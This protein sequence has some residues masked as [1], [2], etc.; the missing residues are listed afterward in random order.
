MI[1]TGIPEKKRQTLCAK[2]CDSYQPGGYGP[3]CPESAIVASGAPDSDSRESGTCSN[4]IR[5]IAAN[6]V[7]NHAMQLDVA[8]F[9][10]W[11]KLML[12]MQNH[13]AETGFVR[14]SRRVGPVWVG[15]N[16]VYDSAIPV[17]PHRLGN[18]AIS[19]EILGYNSTPHFYAS[20][21][22]VPLPLGPGRPQHPFGCSGSAREGTLCQVHDLRKCWTF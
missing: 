15:I 21:C 11:V 7:T 4:L 6:Q 18:L 19:W 5:T 20:P 1:D 12:H 22:K 13:K 14:V 17:N 9:W 16:E 3:G 8:D 2:S 10:V